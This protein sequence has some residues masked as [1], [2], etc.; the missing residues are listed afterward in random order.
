[1]TTAEEWMDT[2]DIPALSQREGELK[3]IIEQ[4]QLDAMK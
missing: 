3:P 1:M 4:I 2:Y